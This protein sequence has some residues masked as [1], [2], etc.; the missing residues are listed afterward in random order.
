MCKL[1]ETTTKLWLF[2]ARLSNIL[3]HL[4]KRVGKNTDKD[5]MD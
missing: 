3:D 4:S 1:S 5:R 2:C